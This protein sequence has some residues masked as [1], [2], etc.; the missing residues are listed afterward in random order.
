MRCKYI[1]LKK[2]KDVLS[3]KHK[4]GQQCTST[5]AP[6][7]INHPYKGHCAGHAKLLSSRGELVLPKKDTDNRRGRGKAIVKAGSKIA[8]VAQ[9]KAKKDANAFVKELA[10][11]TDKGFDAIEAYKFVQQINPY[12]TVAS[13]AEKYLFAM[14][15]LSPQDT[16]T[17][18]TQVEF[19]ELTGMTMTQLELWRV[20]DE[21]LDMFDDHRKSFMQQKGHMVDL[22]LLAKINAGDLKAIELFYT[23][24][25]VSKREI[26]GRGQGVKKD[27]INIDKAVFLEVAEAE[28]DRYKY[29]YQK[30]KVKVITN[31]GLKKVEEKVL[32]EAMKKA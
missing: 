20:G 21:L 12:P 14:W 30:T 27:N 16:R 29:D 22:A 1:Y 3:G 25:P 19:S 10:K 31:E 32:V 18:R 26:G 15:L 5:F 11:L 6:P 2:D 24:F 13:G 9:A 28:K 23:Q 7:D 17:P 8:K 4:E